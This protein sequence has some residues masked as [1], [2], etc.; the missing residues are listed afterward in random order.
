MHFTSSIRSKRERPSSLLAVRAKKERSANQSKARVNE[1][2]KTQTRESL[3]RGLAQRSPGDTLAVPIE[4]NTEPTDTLLICLRDVWDVVTGIEGVELPQS[5]IHVLYT[6]EYTGFVSCT[7]L[8]ATAHES[9]S[10]SG[11]DIIC[12]GR[13]DLPAIGYNT[14]ERERAHTSAKNTKHEAKA[15]G[16]SEITLSLRA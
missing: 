4:T 3:E 5:R 16:K 7:F 8:G 15:T 14:E 2:Y 10:L 12:K 13:K 6:F 9:M 1:V 11:I